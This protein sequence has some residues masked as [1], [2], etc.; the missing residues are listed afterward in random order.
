M[1]WDGQTIKQAI[2]LEC[3]TVLSGT[4]SRNNVPFPII[5]AAFAT[6]ALDGGSDSM[7]SDGGDL[8]LYSDAAG[9]NRLPIDIITITTGVTPKLV[10]RLLVNITDVTADQTV[11]AAWGNGASTQPAVD[12][13][14]GQYA[15]YPDL[16]SYLQATSGEM[17]ERTG[18]HAWTVSNT[19]AVDP[20]TEDCPFSE[21]AYQAG[22]DYTYSDASAVAG[23]I[24]SNDTS[25]LIYTKTNGYSSG[26]TGVCFSDDANSDELT[27]NP[28]D[29]ALTSGGPRVRDASQG[30]NNMYVAHGSSK[31]NTWVHT[32]YHKRAIDD[33]ALSVDGVEVDTYSNSSN[34]YDHTRLNIGSRRSSAPGYNKWC[35]AMFWDAAIT[36]AYELTIV[37]LDSD[38]ANAV[39]AGTPEDIS[40][41]L[42]IADGTSAHT[43]DNVVLV[44]ETSLTI[45]DGASTTSSDNVI[46]GNIFPAQWTR[47]QK[48]EVDASRVPGISSHQNFVVKLVTQNI[49]EKNADAIDVLSNSA[50]NGGDDV[51]FTSDAEGLL[52]LDAHVSGSVN[53]AD[54][55]P[56]SANFVTNA[57]PA[58]Q[59]VD[60]FTRVTLN[61]ISNT[62]F[63][64]WYGNNAAVQP[65]GGAKYGNGSVWEHY[66]TPTG[67]L[68]TAYNNNLNNPTDFI[69]SHLPEH[70]DSDT[71]L[72][73]NDGA[74]ANRTDN[75][76]LGGSGLIIA[77][78]THAHSADNIAIELHLTIADSLHGH[79]ADAI[80]FA[81]SQL[82]NINE[83]SH[84]HLADEP[85]V[86][87]PPNTWAIQPKS[88][89]IWEIQ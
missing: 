42:V 60:V 50:Q 45:A 14:Y 56:H 7:K 24:A 71:V 49:A 44:P 78:S 54:G 6:S 38:P 61:A 65:D 36:Q 63:Y 57:V 88:T 25:M 74:H 27:L 13:A 9:L 31:V 1:A 11:Y 32:G 89:G 48:F 75:V 4:G 80:T 76:V 77:D 58:N 67:H 68:L 8:R 59:D 40:T 64:M 81:Q 29:N 23:L 53:D 20:T 15:T 82:L 21:A 51:Y 17:S 12:A 41:T 62:Q 34:A 35:Y 52:R 70:L 73:I 30:Y 66:T 46:L 5:E 87:V 22:G 28:M 69:I 72:T 19:L 86:R 16:N 47:K 26:Y 33:L 79:T 55:N 10:M 3:A 37:E 2:T 43:A 83:A 84:S 18:N 39:T 85:W